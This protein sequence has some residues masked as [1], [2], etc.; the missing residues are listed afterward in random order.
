MKFNPLSILIAAMLT[1]LFSGCL[2]SGNGG[3]PSEIQT[4]SLKVEGMN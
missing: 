3:S 1:M 2:D 4:I